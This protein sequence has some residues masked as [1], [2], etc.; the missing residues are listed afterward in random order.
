MWTKEQIKNHIKMA[1]ILN[2][3]KDLSFDYI[4]NSIK[5]SEYDVQQFILNKF[6]EFNIDS[7]NNP[8]IVAFN[9]NTSK[10][11]YFPDMNSRCLK[12]GD[13][14]LID[15][16][17]KLK[18]P[19]SPFSDISWMA[20]KGKTVPKDVTKV[21][22]LV[23]TIRNKLIS[24]INKDLANGVIPSGYKLNKL[25]RN[26]MINNDFD[27]KEN[28][29]TG[30]SLGTYSAHGR[31]ANI[32]LS[33]KKYLLKNQGYSIE[34]GIYILNKFGIRSEINFFI[35]SENRLILTTKLQTRI[36]KL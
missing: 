1:Q 25:T 26:F 20:Y 3:I 15:L 9:K 7:D 27:K 14:I 10:V 34:P 17:G 35:S 22:N 19:N 29:Y 18:H 12:D 8:P 13:L 4:K 32:S 30:H 16:W 5:L 31:N 24:S 28:F 6:R 33:N 2:E 11:H 21:W 36:I 23:K